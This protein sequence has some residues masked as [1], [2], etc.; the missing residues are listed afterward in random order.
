MLINEHTA[1][2]SE[3][4]RLEPY[5]KYHVPKYHEWMKD[6]EIQI[7]TA[8]EALTLQEE[9]DMQQSW[10]ADHD[11]LTFIIAG[12]VANIDTL[13]ATKES[14]MLGDVNMFINQVE[15]DNNETLLVG[16][17]ELMIAEKD[18]QGRGYGRAALLL[19]MAYILK[20]EQE[21]M[22]EYS[23]SSTRA[24]SLGFSYFVVK[25]GEDNTRSIALF[26]GLGFAK[27]A[28]NPNYFGEYELRRHFDAFDVS[29]LCEK[30]HVYGYAEVKFEEPA[31]TESVEAR[32]LDDAVAQTKTTIRCGNLN[33]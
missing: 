13:N 10:R 27:T 12:D 1:V 2:H 19:F 17:L 24:T 28:Q 20:H 23:V 31:F 25:I 14:A 33:S 6:P 4:L 22:H 29:A 8:S 16:E 18:L 5:S 15:T 9:Y 21:I 7:A 11:K 32:C 3:R 26:E 30:Y